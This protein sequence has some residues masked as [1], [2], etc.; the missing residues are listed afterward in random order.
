MFRM[1][2]LRSGPAGVLETIGIT[3]GVLILER[4]YDSDWVSKSVV[5][6]GANLGLLLSIALVG[7]LRRLPENQTAAGFSF[8][9]SLCLFSTVVFSESLPVFVVGVV[10]AM[11]AFGAQAPLMTSLYRQNYRGDRRGKLFGKVGVARGVCSV[12]FGWIGGRVMEVDVGNFRWLMLA[13]AFAALLGGLAVLWMPA[14]KPENGSALGHPLGALRWMRVDPLFRSLLI[15]W[16]WVGLAA[17]SLSALNVEYLAN[18]KYGLNFTSEKIAT[19]TVVVPVT[20]RIATTLFWGIAFDRMNFF[21]LRILL[22]GLFGLSFL[23]FF[24]GQQEGFLWAGM[25]LRGVAMG[26]GNIA[27][28]LWVTKLA[29]PERVAEY[30]LVH[31]FLTGIRGVLGPLAAL[32]LVTSVPVAPIAWGGALLLVVGSIMIVPHIRKA[33][34]NS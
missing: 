22:N 1:D 32:W 16:M 24:V 31:T 26:G 11:V 19:M 5:L 15:A 25:A 9:A 7:L 3:F 18:P 13:F 27:W 20:F 10:L 23:L 2:L 21:V 28:N 4:A 33:T 29:P 17:I 8:F 34:L 14:A 12:C 30:M 6:A